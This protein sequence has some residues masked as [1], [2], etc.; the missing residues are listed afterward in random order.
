M[1]TK[2][3][4]YDGTKL[5]SLKDMN[6]NTPEIY[7]CTTN[8]SAGKTTYFNRLLVNRF[9]KSGK[10][11]C[12]IYRFN[13][14]L[15]DCA[16]KFFND[17]Q[18]LFFPDKTMTSQRM[19]SG[20]YHNLFI[21]GSPCGYA[22]SLNSADMIKKYSHFFK[23][24]DSMLF[25][26]FQSETDHYCERELI[27]FFSV[28]TSVARGGGKQSRYVP[29]YMLSNFVS[30][31]NPYFTQLGIASRLQED[32][33]FLRGNGWV[34]EAGFNESAAQAQKDSLFNQ[35]F[36]NNSYFSYITERTYL[37]DSYNF[38]EKVEGNCRYVATLKYENEYYSVK[39]YADKGII[40]CDDSYDPTFPRKI[41]LTTEDHQINYVMLKNNDI[42][43]SMMRQMFLK[44]SFRFKNLKCKDVLIKA[45]SF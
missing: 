34:L 43:I 19:A 3:Q 40:Y 14:E 41:A 21:D 20:I 15:D 8:R 11:F 17:I 2:T 38:I 45:L 4:F 39:E 1:A 36:G 9:L 25:D 37:N 6:G 18:G 30:L 32:T 10:K 35:A 7:L 27:K 5:L 13:Y 28:H 31:L 23:D 33:K 22:V 16:Q 12:L 29:V 26:E 44:G 24:V 42:F